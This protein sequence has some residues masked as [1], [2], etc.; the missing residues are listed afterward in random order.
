MFVLYIMFF[1]LSI[2]FLSNILYIMNKEMI[3]LI[4]CNLAVLLAERNL[5]ITQVSK[6]TGISRTTLTSL[7]NNH[8]QG[9]QMDTLN[10][11]CIYLQVTP[12]QF[13]L[14][15]PFDFDVQVRKIGIEKFE[16]TLEFKPKDQILK[17][18]FIADAEA[19]YYEQFGG[20]LVDKLKVNLKLKDSNNE[21]SERTIV[22]YFKNIPATFRQSIE[23][24]IFDEIEFALAEPPEFFQ[25]CPATAVWS[26][27]LI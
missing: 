2:A 6:D 10:K 15:L 22:K 1:A 14:Y 20:R 24:K 19:D 25:H 13:F 21:Y 8:S 3:I 27:E 26:D 16:V 7:A 11:L 18:T 12:E 23:Q 5:K 4:K 9:I 17:L